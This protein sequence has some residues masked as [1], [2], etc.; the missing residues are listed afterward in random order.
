M[1]KLL[2]KRLWELHCTVCASCDGLYGPCR[3]W[4]AAL[5]AAALTL[6][7]AANF[8]EQYIPNPNDPH[9]PIYGSFLA[10]DIRALKDK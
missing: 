7:F 5:E 1:N 8:V 4:D 3:R 10:R 6:E 9:E 2:E